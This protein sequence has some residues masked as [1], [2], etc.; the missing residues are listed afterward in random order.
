[1]TIKI[2][3]QVALPKFYE[4]EEIT[5]I[6][7]GFKCSVILTNLGRVFISDPIEQKAKA[8]KKD[9]VEEEHKKEKG[10]KKDKGEKKADKGSKKSKGDKRKDSE[11][12]EELK[13]KKP[14]VD[15][16][17]DMTFVSINPK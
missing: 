7:C 15:H 14:K 12:E 6:E 13:A 1:M 8:P 16:W 10:E 9:T 5:K 17:E 3:Q 2:P 11:E 4:K